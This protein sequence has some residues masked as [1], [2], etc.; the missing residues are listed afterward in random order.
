[1]GLEAETF[2]VGYIVH[3]SASNKVVKFP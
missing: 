1:M 3:K 2:I